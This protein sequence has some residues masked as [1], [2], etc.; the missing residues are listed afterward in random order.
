MRSV[1][2]RSSGPERDVW[3]PDSVSVEA[4]AAV[5]PEIV[6]ML[7]NIQTRAIVRPPAVVGALSP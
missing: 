2:R 1:L 6:M 3:S 4:I 5:R 7:A